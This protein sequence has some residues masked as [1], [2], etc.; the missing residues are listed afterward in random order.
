MGESVRDKV[1]PSDDTHES[2]VAVDNREACD[3]GGGKE[4]VS[5]LEGC[6]DIDDDRANRHDVGDEKLCR[7]HVHVLRVGSIIADGRGKRQGQTDR[8]AGPH[9]PRPTQSQW[10]DP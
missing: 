2:A 3:V 6:I 5:I 10:P 1:C 7:V 9:D 8:T 4:V